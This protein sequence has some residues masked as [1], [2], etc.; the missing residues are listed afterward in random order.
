LNSF[1]DFDATLA[2]I[3]RFT[4]NGRPGDA[5]INLDLHGSG[6]PLPPRTPFTRWRFPAD[7]RRYLDEQIALLLATW[8][9][10]RGLDDDAIPCLYPRFGIAEHSAFIGGEVEFSAD[11]SYVH[12]CISDWTDLD[13]LELRDDSPWLRLVVDGLRYLAE[14]SAGRFAVM[15]RGAMAPLDLANA[16]RGND[17]FTDFYDSPGEVHRLL[18]FCTK[19]CSFYL[20]HQ[21]RVV[22]DLAGGTLSG[23][24]VWLPGNAVG[25]LSEDASVLCSPAQYREFGRPYTARVV[26]PFDH[27]FMHLHTAGVRTFPDILSIDRI[28]FIEL[29]NDPNTPRGIEICRRNPALFAGKVV[30]LFVTFDEIQT[31]LDYLRQAKTVLF[32]T[33]AD[34][35]EGRAALDCVRRELPVQSS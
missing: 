13:R 35:E 12:P 24:Y 20:A 28:D 5:L 27:A 4:T 33:V 30:K 2:R 9:H 22:P 19:A 15:Q 1:P 32:C 25:H 18:E 14:Q 26:A 6:F 34:R 29:A 11:T 21:K 16:L 17:L 23:C 7:L 3:R 31:H 10:K 8:E